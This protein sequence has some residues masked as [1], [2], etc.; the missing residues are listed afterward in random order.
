MRPFT[1]HKTTL[2][3][4]VLVIVAVLAAQLVAAGGAAADEPANV[5]EPLSFV[6]DESLEP[7]GGAKEGVATI[8]DS[9]G[10]R[11]DFAADE[12]I[13]VTDDDKAL[14]GLLERRNG[15]LL[16]SFE[17]AEYGFESL[18]PRYLV[19]IDAS[20]AEPEQLASDLERLGVEA[21]GEH[22]LSSQ[23]ALGLFAVAAGETLDGMAVDLNWLAQGTTI[24]TRTTTEAPAADASLPVYTPDAYQWGHLA[25]GTVQDT[26]IGEAW[27]LLARAGRLPVAG[28]GPRIGILDS[29][30]APFDADTP[31]GS[32]QLSSGPGT[33]PCTGGPCPFHG[34]N[35]TS[36]A[37][38]L[39][40]NRF[41]AA[42]AGGP[43]A[44]AIQLGHS[45]DMFSAANGIVLLTGVGA[46]VINMSFSGTLPAAAA[47]FTGWFDANAFAARARGAMLVASAGNAGSD[48]DTVDCFGAC[49]EGAYNWPCETAA[50]FCVGG[51][52]NN[53]K[54]PHSSSN[55]GGGRNLAGS[56]TVDI[57]APWFAVSG[58]D[59]SDTGFATNPNR[60]KN[61]SGTSAAAPVVSGVAA[62]VLAA[63]PGFTP[64][65]VESTLLST[66]QPGSGFASLTIDA[67]GAVTSLLLPNLPPDVSIAQPTNGSSV[68]RG[69]VQFRANASDREDGIPRVRW[70][71]DGSTFLGEGVNVVLS[72]HGLPFGLHRITAVAIDSGGQ[73]VPDADGG[74]TINLVNTPP[75]VSISKPTNG[76]VFYIYRNYLQ[77]G[78]S[79]E[80]I[81][82][83][84]TSSDS[85][86]SPAT[87]PNGQVWWTRNGAYLKGRPRRIGQCARSGDRHAHDHLLRLRLD[88]AACGSERDDRGAG[89]APDRLRAEDDLRLIRACAPIHGRRAR[90]PASSPLR[91]VS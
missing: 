43:V 36:T 88:R 85:N 72:T 32:V 90:R 10:S 18:R 12:L 87:L 59:P 68:P 37:M 63:R 71:A 53:S 38:A 25:N 20:K 62:L 15:K 70:F 56:G 24:R 7:V 16:R 3:W 54:A 73:S 2:G 22:R 4:L 47:A 27:N 9:H 23:E 13:V 61:F 46:R 31:A 66:A 21:R 50:V 34:S 58:I 77:G 14:E 40:D 41:G 26:G 45:G 82:L 76:S 74:V 5:E 60:A 29:G 79:G 52:G 6:V 81:D 1:K 84:G 49:W 83:V 30:F 65:Q 67:Q 69:F 86:N 55:F 78:W 51:L 28:T 8:A 39:V 64:A 57:W 48:V 35:V 89:V 42:G 33:V 80:T 75:S 11:S 91:S 19:H 44:R 17:P